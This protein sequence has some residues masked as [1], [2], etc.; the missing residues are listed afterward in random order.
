VKL[1]VQICGAE[2]GAK[3]YGAEVSVRICGVETSAL[4]ARTLDADPLG[5]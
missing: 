5:P 3:I 1:G 2:L 4:G